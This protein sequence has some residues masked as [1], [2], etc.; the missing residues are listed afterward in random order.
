MLAVRGWPH[1]NA[2]RLCLSVSETA[3]HLCKNCS[4]TMAI[5]SQVHTWDNVDPGAPLAA[6]PLPLSDGTPSLGVRPRLNNVGLVG[7]CYTSSG[8]PGKRGTD[9]SSM[10][11][12]SHM[13]RW[14]QLHVRTSYRESELS[15]SKRLPFRWNLIRFFLFVLSMVLRHVLTLIWICQSCTVW[16]SLFLNE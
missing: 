6:L 7:G 10:A 11:N 1:N 12:I 5:W 2:C 3:T 9:V 8:I 4:F 16:F 13:S 15:R 14:L